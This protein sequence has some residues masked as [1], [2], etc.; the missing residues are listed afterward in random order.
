MV[1]KF[2]NT[3]KKCRNELSDEIKALIRKY[4]GT[5]IICPKCMH[6]GKLEVRCGYWVCQHEHKQCL[7][8]PIEETKELLSWLKRPGWKA[9]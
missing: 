4:N 7:L 2:A 8:E 6:G 9:L 3:L 1:K 5:I